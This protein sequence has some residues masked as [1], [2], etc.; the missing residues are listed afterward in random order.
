LSGARCRPQRT[1]CT[2]PPGKFFLLGGATSPTAPAGILRGVAP[3]RWRQKSVRVA[4]ERKRRYARGAALRGGRGYA[5]THAAAGCINPTY[6][7]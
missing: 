2:I 4:L 7:W 6:K 3:C 5:P 1:S